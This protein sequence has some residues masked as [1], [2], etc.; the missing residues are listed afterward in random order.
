MRA[1]SHPGDA[2]PEFIAVG[3]LMLRYSALWQLFDAV[4][5]VLSEALRA[6]CDTTWCMIVRIVLAWVVWVPGAWY[7]VVELEGG[8]TAVMLAMVAYIALLAAAF[9]ARFLSGVGNRST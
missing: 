3:V 5:I 4:G 6:A 9:A 8:V 7:F 2:L 1:F